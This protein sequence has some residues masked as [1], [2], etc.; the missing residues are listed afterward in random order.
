MLWC[1]RGE[2]MELDGSFLS[3]MV[4]FPPSIHHTRTCH[5]LTAHHYSRSHEF[6]SLSPKPIG[7]E[8]LPEYSTS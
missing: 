7:S 6:I 2:E 1:Q 4:K 8:E 5:D 3:I